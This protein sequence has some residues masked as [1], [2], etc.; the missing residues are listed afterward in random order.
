MRPEGSAQPDSNVE[1]KKYTTIDVV[2]EIP[3][4]AIKEEGILKS[5]QF[6]LTEE[7]KEKLGEMNECYDIYLLNQES[8]RINVSS[9]ESIKIR[10]KLKEGETFIGVYEITE[11][12]TLK[13]VNYAK[14]DN[15]IEIKTNKLGKYVISYKDTITDS[16][17][18]RP[19][20]KEEKK[21]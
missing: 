5:E 21:D 19:V 1:Y 14:S 17:D 10:V 6:E 7:Q 20:K 12:N 2:V 15:S 11:T 13:S 16:V 3:K 9:E 4:S 18:N 8:K